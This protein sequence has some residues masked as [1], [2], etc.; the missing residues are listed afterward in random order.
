[1]NGVVDFDDYSRTGNSFHNG[2]GVWFQGDFNY[3][4]R[5]DF[6]DYSLID[7]A[8]NTQSGTLR[9]AMSYLNGEDRSANGM[10]AGALRIVADHFSRFGEPYAASFLAA[11]PE[12][13]SLVGCFGAISLIFA[14]SR[15]R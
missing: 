14:R 2:G 10:S 13:G 9:R 1:L 8:F 4:G 12:P 5:V 15:R 6:D 7:M 3:N 11:V